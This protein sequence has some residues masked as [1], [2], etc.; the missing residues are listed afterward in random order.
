MSWPFQYGPG[1]L[2]SLLS[3]SFR[4]CT[5][6]SAVLSELFFSSLNLE[7]S[8]P[9]WV[10]FEPGLGEQLPLLSCSFRVWTWRSAVLTELFVSSLGLQIR[11]TVNYLLRVRT[12]S[13]TPLWIVCFEFGPGDQQ[14]WV[15]P[16][17]P[18]SIIYVSA[19]YSAMHYVQRK[20]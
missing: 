5:W 16:T 14:S 20:A 6:R 7:I 19:C 11:G 13:L 8:C 18:T 9:Y 10:R 4:V 1:D 3:C 15:I 2:Q 17:S 12:W